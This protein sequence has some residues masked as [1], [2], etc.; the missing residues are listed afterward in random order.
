MIKFGKVIEVDL[1]GG[2]ARVRAFAEG[3]ETDFLPVLQISTERFKFYAMPKVDE[4]VAIAVDESWNGVVLGSIYDDENPP[5]TNGEIVALNGD[6]FGGLLKA[7]AFLS[8]FQ[9]LKEMVDAMVQAFESWSPVPQDGGASLK[10]AMSAAVAGKT[11]GNY[12]NMINDK[13]KHG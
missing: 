5:E 13:I 7:V 6:E 4:I 9:K 1:V 2:R 8:E 10:A 11:T 3:I 12:E